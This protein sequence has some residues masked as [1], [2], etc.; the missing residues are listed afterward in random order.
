[1]RPAFGYSIPKCCVPDRKAVTT[2]IKEFGL[3]R[4]VFE[5]TTSR[6]QFRYTD[7]RS[8]VPVALDF[9]FALHVK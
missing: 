4:P 3:S 8:Y 6:Y 1:M 9:Y 2:N 5:P 7:Q